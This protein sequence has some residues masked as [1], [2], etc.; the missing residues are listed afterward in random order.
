MENAYLRTVNYNF[1]FSNDINFIN[2]KPVFEYTLKSNY[3]GKK[4]YNFL[5]TSIISLKI[6]FAFVKNSFYFNLSH[7]AIGLQNT[8]S[9]DYLTDSRQLFSLYPSRSFF[10]SVIPI[11]ELFDKNLSSN[12]L[13][14][15]NNNSADYLLYSSKY[16]LGWK[17][18]LSNNSWDLLIP[19]STNLTVSRDLKASSVL[20]D[21]YQFK[22]SANNMAFN[23]F[24]AKS[25]L[26]LFNWYQ[27]DEIISNLTGL[28]KVPYDL[29]ENTVF[30]ITSYLQLIL[31]FQEKYNNLNNL[32]IA[33]DLSLASD[34]DYSCR[35]TTIWSR[36]GKFSLLVEIISLF[37]K[38][39]LNQKITIK[40]T[41]NLDFKNSDSLTYQSYEYIHKNELSLLK[42][43]T[44]NYEAGFVYKHTKDS[45]DSLKLKLTIGG[46]MEF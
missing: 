44:L 15:Q 45:G 26:Q 5:D 28:V 29:S 46:K 19:S 34:N 6:P 16:E 12:I 3:K 11:Y 41:L 24:G 14:A 42:Y 10:Y 31:Y 23:I 2:L 18:R 9:K 13:L 8:S 7:T 36:G 30:Q 22:L 25:N 4:S 35:F 40:D 17:R 39:S 37:Y 43:Y 27:Q 32:K 33:G 20:S 21:L 1:T 38:K